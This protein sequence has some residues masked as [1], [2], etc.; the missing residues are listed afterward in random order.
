LA[1]AFIGQLLKALGA[2][3]ILEQGYVA[4]SLRRGYSSVRKQ[5]VYKQEE[6]T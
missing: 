4:A 2:V 6:G 3:G 5:G 1:Q